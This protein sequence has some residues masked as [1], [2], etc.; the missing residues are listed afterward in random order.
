MILDSDSEDEVSLSVSDDESERSEKSGG[1][2]LDNYKY[3]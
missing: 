1:L 2:N 3:E